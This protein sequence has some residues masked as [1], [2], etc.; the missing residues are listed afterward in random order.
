[1]PKVSIIIPCHNKEPYLP[2]CLNSVLNQSLHDI[3]VL[4]IDDHSTDNTLQILEYFQKEYPF[5]LKIFS[6]DEKSG[7]SAARN[8]G[9][10]YAQGEY[11]GFVDADDVVTLNMY[12]DFYSIAKW[13]QVPMVVGDFHMFTYTEFL[14]QEKIYSYQK[15][16]EKLIDYLTNDRAFFSVS[17]SCWDKLFLHDHI[18]DT[19][20][21]EN[22]IFEDLGFTYTL[23]LH[24]KEACQV[25]RKD[26]FYRQTPNGIIK[27]IY[28]PNRKLLD[29]LA[30]CLDMQ[31]FGK[32]KHFDSRQMFLLQEIIKEN[33]LLV[34]WTVNDWKIPFDKKIRLLRDI[35]T[36]FEYYFPKFRKL[37]TIYSRNDMVAFWSSLIKVSKIDSAQVQQKYQDVLKLVKSLENSSYH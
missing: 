5:T 11:I 15:P 32:K 23:L 35:I 2:T 30:V 14:H 16:K 19:R 7:V 33:L 24:A 1:M 31:D 12:Q 22:A 18:G 28:H 27:S 25:N 3:E 36:V 37:K 13:Y 9:L 8:L 4:A 17:A 29:M 34:L 26:Y 20:F 6:L 10:E 21:L